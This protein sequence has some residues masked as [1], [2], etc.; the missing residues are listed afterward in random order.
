MRRIEPEIAKRPHRGAG[1]PSRNEG[2]D[3][4]GELC[5]ALVGCLGSR[6]ALVALGAD[7][8]QGGDTM[9]IKRLAFL[10]CATAAMGIGAANAGP[11]N[12]KDA[13]SGPTPG[14]TGPSQTTGSATADT[15]AHPP[16]DTMNRMAGE[17]ATSSQDAQRQQQ[18]Q[19][20][21]AQEAQ[22][23]KSTQTA[24]QGC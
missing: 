18:G 4:S 9:M 11:C 1:A 19:P 20:T 15:P 3:F 16:T 2:Y 7:D 8:N 6:A 12:G 13:G 21:A 22:G 14:Y 24:N 23:A 5:S 10:V 17:K